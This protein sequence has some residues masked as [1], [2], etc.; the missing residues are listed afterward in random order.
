VIS[1]CNS[2]PELHYTQALELKRPPTNRPHFAYI[3]SVLDVNDGLMMKK[4]KNLP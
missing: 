3:K 2:S 4:G 1:S